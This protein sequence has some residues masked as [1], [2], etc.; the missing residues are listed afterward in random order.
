MSFSIP[1]RSIP[2]TRAAQNRQ[3]GLE[4]VAAH[5]R[6]VTTVLTLK[7]LE[8]LRNSNTSTPPHGSLTPRLAHSGKGSTMTHKCG[9]G[10]T[11]LP[12][13]CC[14]KVSQS[15]LI[16]C[17]ISPET[18]RPRA[19]EINYKVTTQFLGVLSAFTLSV[20]PLEKKPVTSGPRAQMRGEGAS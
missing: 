1:L 8:A 17:Q 16:C 12:P 13:E 11:W 15:L 9:V 14:D 6:P 19:S 2:W 3:A 10:E 20:K 4:G 5:L 7:G 18:T